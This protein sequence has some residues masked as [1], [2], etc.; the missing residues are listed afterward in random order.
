MST[1]PEPRISVVIP[2]RNRP[3]NLRLALESLAGQT[4]TPQVVIGAMEYTDEYVGI[5]REFTGRLPIVSVLSAAPWRVGEA[6][7][8][9]LRQATG[10]VLVLMDVDMALPSRALETL[11]QRHFGYGQRVCVAGQLLGYDNNTGDVAA[12]DARPY[13]H[14]RRTLD[15]LQAREV[16]DEDPRLHVP[17]VIPWAFAWTALI[18]LRRA[19]TPFFD[20]AFTGYGVEDLEWAYRVSRAGTPIIMGRDFYGVHL[21]HVRDVAANRRTEAVNYRY[22]LRRWPGH[23]VELACALGDVGANAAYPALLDELGEVRPS[24]VLGHDGVLRIGVT[25]EVAAEVTVAERLP[26]AGLALP[27]AD[28]ALAEARL[29]PA[30]LRLSPRFLD[31]VRAEARRVA[32][33]VIEEDPS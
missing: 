6:R 23:D 26:I 12:V 5:C 10:E 21:P 2:Y 30:V 20:E 33:T 29:L 1:L 8:L 9:A 16:V 3:D 28:G 4:L 18:A 31:P 17:H 15:E 22:F 11:Y 32:R 24:V 19:D 25:G 27:Y 13:A 7:N 14:Y